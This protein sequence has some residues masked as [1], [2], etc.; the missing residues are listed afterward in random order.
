M[1]TV[2]TKPN[3]VMGLKRKQ[4]VGCV[5]SAERG[6]RMM[7]E[8]GMNAAREYAPPLI[9]FPCMH[10]KAEL[11]NGAPPGSISACH[12]SGWMQSD[13]FVEWFHHFVKHTNPTANRPVSLR[14]SHSSILS[15]PVM[16]PSSVCLLTP[17]IGF[18][19][20]MCSS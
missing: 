12:K 1:T 11:M 15:E 20:L 13:I 19:H 4:Q 3:K 18:S 2:Q 9:T 5:T 16:S 8:V 6:T 17:H 7:V 10:M 14:A